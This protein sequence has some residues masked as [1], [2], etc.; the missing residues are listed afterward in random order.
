MAQV[1]LN[2]INEAKDVLDQ[3]LQLEK[4]NELVNELYSSILKE[5]AQQKEEEATKDTPA[6]KKMEQFVEWH[7][8]YVGDGVMDKVAI[9]WANESNRTMVAKKQLKRGEVLLRAPF[10]KC[11]TLEYVGTK[12]CAV[13]RHLYS[14]D[15][16]REK[17]VNSSECVKKLLLKGQG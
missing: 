9:K 6:R 1:G 12:G 11:L 15:S 16:S 13:N 8:Q 2:K 17:L 3:A 7:R 14:T 5:M 4:E 10:E